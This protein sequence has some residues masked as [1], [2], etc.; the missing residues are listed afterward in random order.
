[1]KQFAKKKWRLLGVVLVTLIVGIIGCDETQ[2][3]MK[4]VVDETIDPK[5]TTPPTTVDEMK[6]DEADA[7]ED[8]PEAP[9][10]ITLTLPTGY[11]LPS[12]LTPKAI[13]RSE[14]EAA[15]IAVDEFIRQ[16]YI[17]D[18][19]PTQ[20][21]LQTQAGKTADLLSVLPY[22]AREEVYDLFVASINLPSFAE[23][24]ER[25]KESNIRLRISFGNVL[26]DANL[27][28]LP[29]DQKKGSVE[30]GDLDV[31][32]DIY[33]EENPQDIP[34]RLGHSH[35]WM[36]L[37]YYRLQLEN[38]ELPNFY[39]TDNPAELLKLFRESAR[40]GWI[41]GLENPWR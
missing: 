25:V 34:Y 17:P 16:N 35:Y 31:L 29:D 27:D 4:P 1:M 36:I 13:T 41:F 40:K 3:M 12:E 7:D 15:L 37:E 39:T 19:D 6:Q 33:F 30:Q 9:E 24:A 18:F 10:Q 20:P 22:E 28:L 38:P 26:R 14:N 8:E 11:E 32:A 5:D 2:L 21:T 23:A